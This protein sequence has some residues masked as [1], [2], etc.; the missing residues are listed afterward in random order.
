MQDYVTNKQN[1]IIMQIIQK[2]ILKSDF[3]PA[4]TM[5]FYFVYIYFI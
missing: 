1:H 3:L 2:K 4:K 5:T